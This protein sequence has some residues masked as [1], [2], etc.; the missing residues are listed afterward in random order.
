MQLLQ[1]NGHIGCSFLKQLYYMMMHFILS[2]WGKKCEHLCYRL[3]NFVYADY[4]RSLK[5]QALVNTD[6]NDKQSHQLYRTLTMVYYNQDYWVSG[7]WPLS[8]IVKVHTV[9]ET[10]LVSILRWTVWGEICSVGTTKMSAISIIGHTWAQVL[11]QEI[12]WRCTITA[13][14]TRI[15]DRGQSP[16]RQSSWTWVQV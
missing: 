11:F 4:D 3:P 10:L 1:S 5:H 16:K 14:G 6:V 9:S 15:L 12:K 8:N 2:K 13:V 7:L